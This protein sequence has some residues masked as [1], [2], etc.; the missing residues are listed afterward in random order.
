M[1]VPVKGGFTN[2]CPK[3]VYI[4]SNVEPKYWYQDADARSIKAM[5]RRLDK[6]EFINNPL[7]DDIE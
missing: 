2:W 3:K 6:I 7:Y 1:K 4:T 5:L